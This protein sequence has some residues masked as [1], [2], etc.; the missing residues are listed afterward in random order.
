MTAFR[1]LPPL[2]ALTLL[3]LPLLAQ[4]AAPVIALDVGHFNEKPGATSA[5]GQTELSFNQALEPV[6]SDALKQHGATPIAIGLAGD[7]ASLTAR[8]RAAEA[9]G[10][11]FFLSLHHDSTQARFIQDWDWQGTQQQYSDRT[12]GFSLFVSRLNP[13]VAQSLKCAS[14]IGA[15]LVDAG[16]RPNESHGERIPGESKEWA[17]KA[18]GVYYFDNLVVLKT[19]TMPAALLESGVIVNRDEELTLAKPET[20]QAIAKAVADGL[21]A[22]GM[23]GR[24]E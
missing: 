8:T 9:F 19:A 14:A 24:V 18:H 22:C 2:A 16:F 6:V 21:A 23:I 20:R 11:Q 15:A 1:A 13:H 12:S 17:D 4:A 5:R 10:A 7:M 3:A